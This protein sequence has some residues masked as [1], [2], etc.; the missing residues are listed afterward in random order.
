MGQGVGRACCRFQ[1]QASLRVRVLWCLGGGIP[2][3][4][5][6]LVA[7]EASLMGNCHLP[8]APELSLPLLCGAEPRA[9]L[10]GVE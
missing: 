6:L 3:L 7:M 10:R 2:Q 4:T 9:T 1:K 8:G 5:Q